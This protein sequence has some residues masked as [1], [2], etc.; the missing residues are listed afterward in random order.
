MQASNVNQWKNTHS[1][2][3]WFNKINNKGN[4]T[5]VIFDIESFYPSISPKLFEDAVNY[6]K[7]ICDVS[8]EQMSLILQARKT[9]LF[10]N[11]EAW[12]KKNADEDFDVPM[13]CFDGAEVCEL[14]GCY[15][16]NKI[17]RIMNPNDVG[18]YRDD[19]LGVLRNLSGPQVDKKRRPNQN[20]QR[21]W[22]LNNLPDKYKKS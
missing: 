18:L 9:L 10:H 17:K 1:V 7:T 16:L 14:V 2:I 21:L 6:A 8:D 3:D 5:F 22:T 20:L 15:I 13:G 4:C 12:V 11:D 19:G